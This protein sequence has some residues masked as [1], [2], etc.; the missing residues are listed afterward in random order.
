MTSTTAKSRK[1]RLLTA[2]KRDKFLFLLLIPALLYYTIFFY[3]PIGGIVIAFKDYVPGHGV[4]GGEWVGLKWFIQFFES[5]FAKRLI[6]NTI[7]INLY[8]ILFGFP[9]PILFAICVTEIRN[10]KVRRTVQTVSYLPHFVSTVAMVG[11]IKNLLALDD[12]L[13]NN[14][15]ALFGGQRVNFLMDP[16]AY[17]TIY[18]GSGIWQSFGFDSIIYIAAIMGVDPSLYEAGKID[19]IGKFQEARYITLPMISQTI[20]IL[21]ILRLGSIMNVGFE[22]TFLLYN[23]SVYETADV[24]GTYVYRKGIQSNSFSFSAAVGL[25]N[26][27]I[28][29]LFVFGANWISRKTTQ[30]SLW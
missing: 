15:I 18:V 2:L 22:K 19:G 21:F 28:N 7:L 11:I 1:S 26:S 24:I 30:M 27:A 10:M 3:I 13:V 20:I 16:A 6:R 14:L 8:S 25:F 29:F 23:E 12:G 5:V 17:R 4:Y 9:V